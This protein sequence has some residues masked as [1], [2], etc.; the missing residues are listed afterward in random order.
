MRRRSARAL[1]TAVFLAAVL[2]SIALAACGAGLQRGAAGS[3]PSS[4]SLAGAKLYV[5][6]NNAAAQQVRELRAQGDAHDADLLQRI[7]DQPTATWFADGSQSVRAQAR[8]L[9]V[10]AAT[11]RKMAVIVA[12][13]IPERDC[14]G[15]YSAGGAPS[16]AAYR[17]W[18]AKLAAG[19]GTRRTI[20]VLEPDALADA[21]SG[22][23]S[24]SAIRRRLALLRGAVATLRRNSAAL[25]YLDAGNPDWIR[26]P[27]RLIAPLRA[28]GIA[29][30]SGFALNVANFQTTA[31][32]VAYGE[33]LSRLLGGTHFVIDT[34]RNGN[35]PDT[36]PADAPDWC[37]PP[38]R[39]LGHEPSTSTGR[40]RLDAYLWIKQPG[41]SD[42][43]CRAGGPPAGSFWLEYALALATNSR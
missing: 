34:S 14:G 15:G 28:A 39:A 23:L 40:P 42:G 10:A 6:P 17:E 5:D 11:Q 16:A 19:I 38:G 26:S 9:T 43:S 30:A 7:A 4:G 32:N 35:G 3:D 24:E 8:A 29:E 2:F 25:V 22:C 31:A 13:D 41:E 33:K 1:L 12:Y 18:I 20:V 27:R 36:N 21:L 37:N